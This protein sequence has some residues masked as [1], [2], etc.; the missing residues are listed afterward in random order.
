[1]T[2]SHS[3]RLLYSHRLDDEDDNQDITENIQGLK[4]MTKKDI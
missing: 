2:S 4:T 3:S 1:M